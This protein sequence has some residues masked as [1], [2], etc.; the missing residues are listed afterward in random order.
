MTIYVARL[1]AIVLFMTV[2]SGLSYIVH[3]FVSGLS[4]QGTLF[5]S[6]VV[7]GIAICYGLWCLDERQRKAGA[8]SD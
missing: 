6:G 4:E 2:M 1:V 8:R 3:G 7:V 5:G